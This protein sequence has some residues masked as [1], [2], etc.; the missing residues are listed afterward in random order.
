VPSIEE[1]RRF[2]ENER[3]WQRA[4]ARRF[5]WL[6]LV[7]VGAG[8]IS[9]LEIPHAGLAVARS[10]WLVGLGLGE[11]G[12]KGVVT[13]VLPLRGTSLRG[14]AAIALGIIHVLLAGGCFAFGMWAWLSPHE[15][16]GSK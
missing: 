1:E 14:H 11:Q 12:L 16:I 15:L 6:L 2:W 3:A 4:M 7:G 9:Y 8:L 10:L 13:R 5:N